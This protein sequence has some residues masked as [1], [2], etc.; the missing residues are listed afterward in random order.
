MLN[1]NKMFA[2]YEILIVGAGL[3]GLH[4][5]LRLVENYKKI[6]IAE[7]YDY[8]GG[9][10]TTYRPK[11]YS[12]QWENG[13]GR[14]HT[15][16]TM[17]NKY[18]KRYKLTKIPIDPSQEWISFEPTEDIWSSLVEII[19]KS[20]QTLSPRILA[21]H[22][23]QELLDATYGSG[24]TKRL[25]NH[26]AYR[27]EINTLR[28]DLALKAFEKEFKSTKDFYVVKEGLDTIVYGMKAELEKHGVT[29]LMNH[30]LNA[31][32]SGTTPIV[33]KFANPALRITANKVILALHSEALKNISP[34]H[35]LPILKHL[36]MK[37]LLRT[38]AIFPTP[39]GKAWFH[40]IQKTV[41]AHPIRFVIPMD[42]AKGTI[43]TSYTDNNDAEHWIH[44]LDK[45]RERGLEKKI[46][47]G[48]RE[49]FPHKKIP[50]PLYFKA[51]PWYEGCTYWLPG[52]YDPVEL[53]KKVM[54]PLPGKW[55]HLYVC[56][57]SFSMR[58]AWMEGAL[59][60]AEAMIKKYF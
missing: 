5:A 59:E 55:Q 18:V 22:T 48:L 26:F 4:C 36:S 23:I 43:M 10:V 38:Y 15:S 41:T 24:S 37:P 2:D 47:K 16:H 29:F 60:H 31:V 42:P 8:V 46:M 58:Q 13:A 51:H 54:C 39:N 14:V 3:A 11:D 30:K 25:L 56:G 19:T 20:L 17:V 33:C 21:T 27:S 35:N 12:V 9:R 53:S 32:E 28:A 6:A 1:N 34:F 49:L 57:E 45:E 40:D 52:S 44:I 7:A 50:D